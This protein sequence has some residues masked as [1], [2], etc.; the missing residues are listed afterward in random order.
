MTQFTSSMFSCGL[1]PVATLTG[2]SPQ[3]L[4]TT[5]GGMADVQFHLFSLLKKVT[6]KL[7]SAQKGKVILITS[8]WPSKL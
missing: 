1:I 2:C 5:F 3:N 8:W 7:Q 4:S 6:Q